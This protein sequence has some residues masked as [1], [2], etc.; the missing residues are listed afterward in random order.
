MSESLVAVVERSVA[1][2]WAAYSKV[3]QRNEKIKWVF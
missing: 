1:G 2:R 3:T